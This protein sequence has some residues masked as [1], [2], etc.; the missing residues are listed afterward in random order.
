MAHFICQRKSC[1]NTKPLLSIMIWVFLWAWGWSRERFAFV[2]TV[3]VCTPKTTIYL[4]LPLS[5][6]DSQRPLEYRTADLPPHPAKCPVLITLNGLFKMRWT[7]GRRLPF[8]WSQNTWNA[9]TTSFLVQ[10]LIPEAA[11]KSLITGYMGVV[12]CRPTLPQCVHASVHMAL[13]WP[14]VSPQVIKWKTGSLFDL[15][16]FW[17]ISRWG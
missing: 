3:L 16:F 1:I 7:Q 2:E 6:C 17:R 5:S 12:T 11:Q 15:K 4:R 8:W 13:A 9:Q 14:Y 10:S